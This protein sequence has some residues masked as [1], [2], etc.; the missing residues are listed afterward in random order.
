MFFNKKKKIIRRCKTMGSYVSGIDGTMISYMSDFL[1]R[2]KGNTIQATR[3][4]LMFVGATGAILSTV[5]IT[6]LRDDFN[7]IAISSQWAKIQHPYSPASDIYMNNG[8]SSTDNGFRDLD[9]NDQDGIN[10]NGSD[11]GGN[12]GGWSS[13]SDSDG[14]SFTNNNNNHNNNNNNG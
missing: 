1:M 11:N 6:P 5:P 7:A 3:N 8:S 14:S 12:D 13:F 9:E 2:D 4:Y 10:G